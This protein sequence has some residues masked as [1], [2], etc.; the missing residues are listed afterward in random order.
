MSTTLRRIDI[1]LVC[2]ICE[3]E[4]DLHGGSTT[5]QCRHCGIAFTVD[6][7]ELEQLS[8]SA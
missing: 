6:D 4:I 1:L 5:A 3:G 8:R 2:D 7:P